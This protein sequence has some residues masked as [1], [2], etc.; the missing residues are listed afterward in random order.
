MIISKHQIDGQDV[1]PAMPKPIGAASTLVLCG[2]ST[3]SVKPDV[4][5]WA[6]ADPWS[7]YK[8][9]GAPAPAPPPA[10]E[11]LKQL[12]TRLYDAIVDK[13]P[14]A[15]L[16]DQELPD[17][18]QMLEGQV[19]QLMTKHQQLETNMADFTHQHGKQITGLQNQITAQGQQ[20]HGQ[21]ETQAQSIAAMFENQMQQIRG[22]L[23][24]RPH[25]SME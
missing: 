7:G 20:F 15:A 3:P 22:L 6:K 25:D 18:M 1:K 4:D 16:M 8:P 17:R 19:H 21:I 9:V 11:S 24:K 5:P 14:T 10:S 23:A 12:E 13:L 2:E